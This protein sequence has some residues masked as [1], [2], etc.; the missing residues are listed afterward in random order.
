M[1][2]RDE[3][4]R[5]AQAHA[6]FYANHDDEDL[7]AFVREH[8]HPDIELYFAGLGNEPRGLDSFLQIHSADAGFSWNDTVMEV[9]RLVV[10]DDSFVLKFAIVRWRSHEADAAAVA[11]EQSAT[12]GYMQGYIPGVNI[13][14]VR[15]GKV[16]RTDSMI[17][18]SLAESGTLVN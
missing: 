1:T 6:F 11:G 5:I 13:Y 10:G 9:E 8:W 3:V 14:T 7:E 4:Q 16:V 15:D 2:E 18:T 12:A 17:M